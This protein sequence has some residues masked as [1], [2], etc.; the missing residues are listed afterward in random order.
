MARLPIQHVS[1]ATTGLF[2]ASNTL[3]QTFAG[4]TVNSN[5]APMTGTHMSV[6]AGLFDAG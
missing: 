6:E 2:S 3:G 1:L 4:N 5:T